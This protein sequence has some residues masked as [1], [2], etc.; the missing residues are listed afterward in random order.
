VG[1]SVYIMA[2]YGMK[3]YLIVDKVKIGK[4]SNIGLHSYVMAAE[5][6][7][8]AA[9]YPNSAVLPKTKIPPFAKFGHTD[10]VIEIRQKSNE[11]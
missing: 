8:N 2:H 6:G 1:G 3:G 5:I 10:Q 7:E 9:V 4:A 11:A